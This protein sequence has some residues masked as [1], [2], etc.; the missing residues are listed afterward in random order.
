[1]KF[2]FFLVFL[3]LA[4]ACFSTSTLAFTVT[5]NSPAADAVLPLGTHR[6]VF[7]ASGASPLNCMV[8]LNESPAVNTTAQKN[9]P[10][11]VSIN[12]STGGFFSWRA[13]CIDAKGESGE[14]EAR[15]VQVEESKIEVE[16][17]GESGEGI[18]SVVAPK[19]QNA[20]TLS[21]FVVSSGGEREEA[22]LFQ[23]W[24]SNPGRRVILAALFSNDGV[25]ELNVSLHVKILNESTDGAVVALLASDGVAIAPGERRVLQV[26]WTPQSQGA[27]IAE[28]IIVSVDGAEFQ[29]AF[30]QINVARADSADWFFVVA[31]VCL[32]ALLVAL[33]K[34]RLN[35]RAIRDG[36]L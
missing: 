15:R 17:S 4:V 10:V 22:A 21:G 7:T 36:W 5:L 2:S 14:S 1:M 3:S 19:P 30:L 18:A 34:T 33:F 25:N 23:S 6:F 16:G 11:A 20:G 28:G 13:R 35:A 31:F 26:E 8:L 29:K 12:F 24:R 9:L 32:A 27:F